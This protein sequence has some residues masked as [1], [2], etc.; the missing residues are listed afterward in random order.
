[1]QIERP[2]DPVFMKPAIFISPSVLVGL[3]FAFQEWM[4]IRHMGYHLPALLVVESWGF[5]L[6]V[7]GILC[8]L[9]WRFLGPQIQSASV[10]S[11][12]IAF[13]PLSVAISIAQQM[14]FVFIFRNLPLN[15]PELSYWQRLSIYVY[16]E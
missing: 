6:L 4:S 12:I 5:Q 1:M 7:W 2:N 10:F 14:L 9:L 11:I 15:H 16:A 8:W 13:L 3:L